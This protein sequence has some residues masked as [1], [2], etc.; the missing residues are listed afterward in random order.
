MCLDFCAGWGNRLTGFMAAPNV[1]EIDLI[2][3][4]SDAANAYIN[5]HHL[6]G[7]KTLLNVYRG[8]AEDVLPTLHR[9][10]DLIISSPPYMNLEIYTGKRE[11]GRHLQVSERY[12]DVKAYLEDFL[13]PITVTCLKRLRTNGIFCINISDSR[14]KGIDVC[15]VFLE[16]VVKLTRGK[17]KFVGT[18]GYAITPD[19]NFFY[20][21]SHGCFVGE[22]IYVFSHAAFASKARK[23]ISDVVAAS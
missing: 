13:I 10:Y 4:R 3:P 14:K 12:A 9:K 16:R 21:K 2:E 23:M 7:S 1:E 15:R 17:Y 18:I 5:Q 6:V 22:P 19:R 11:A 8:A 20:K